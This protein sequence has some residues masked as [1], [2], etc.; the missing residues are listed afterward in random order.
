MTVFEALQAAD[1][2]G[3]DQISTR[4]ID[5]YSVQPIDAVTLRTALEDTGLIVVVEDHLRAGGLGDAVLDA[6]EPRPSG[7]VIKLCVDEMPGSASPQ[8]QRH[9][10]GISA[11]AIVAAV[12][13]YSQPTT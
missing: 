1:Q 3:H 9:L 2:L 7:K 11:D 13:K 4:V 8:Q 6:L 12:R 5:A 10:A